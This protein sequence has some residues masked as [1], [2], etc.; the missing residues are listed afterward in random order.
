MIGVDTN[1]LVRY[2]VVDD[3]DQS[4]R[5]AEFLER[6]I[7]ADAPGFVSVVVLAELI[8]VLER[9]YRFSPNVIVEAIESVLRA[10]VLFI[11]RE[12]EVLAALSAFKAQRGA[13]ADALIGA[14][15]AEVGCSHTVTFDKKAAR[16]P[17]FRLL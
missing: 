13:F 16:L 3:E 10:E 1:V 2:F 9:N 8:W 14:L 15:A 4:R 6:S 7:S 17:G 11:D 5:A 12:P